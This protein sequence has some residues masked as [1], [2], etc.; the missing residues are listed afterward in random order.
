MLNVDIQCMINIYS[1]SVQHILNII[2]H[3]LNGTGEHINCHMLM[4]VVHV[5]LYVVISHFWRVFLVISHVWSSIHGNQPPFEAIVEGKAGGD[6]R[7]SP[8]V[9][10]RCR[11]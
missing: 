11:Q 4:Y 8:D 9:L 2:Q 5:W 6:D 10:K 7:V 1:V 3:I